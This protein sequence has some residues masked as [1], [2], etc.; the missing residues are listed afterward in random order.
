MW[1]LV[2]AALGA[3]CPVPGAL[4]HFE[5]TAEQPYQVGDVGIDVTVRA[6]D[7]NGNQVPLCDAATV[8]GLARREAGETVA[9]DTTGPFAAGEVVLKDVFVTG[10]S[11]RVALERG[12]AGPVAG[13]YRPRRLPG[14]L[15]ILPPLFAI[16]LAIWLRRALVALVAGVWLGALFVHDFSPMTALLKTFDTYLPSTLTDSGHAA[17]VLFTMALGG[18]VGVI[19]KSGGTKALVDIMARRAKSRRSAQLVAWLSGMVVF[20]DDYANCLLVGNTVRP[21]ADER[22]ISREKLSFLVD[23]TAAPV[24]TVALVSTWIGYQLGL[25][26]GAGV[27]LEG[28]AYDAFLSM[29][30]YSFYALFALGFVGLIAWSGRDFGPMLKAE[31]RAIATGD[32]FRPGSQPLLDKEL[33]ELQPPEGKKL[34]WQNA[35]LPIGVVVGTVIIGLYFNGR[36][37]VEASEGAAAADAASV[38]D[39]IGS[40]DSYAVLLWASFLGGLVAIGSVLATRTLDISE[41]MDAWVGGAKAMV[42]AVLILV[43]AWAIG[44]MC[45]DHLHTGDW[46]L[47]Q[48]RPSGAWLPL[49]TFLVSAVIALAT[50]SSF[51]TMAIVIPLAAPMVWAVT[52]GDVAATADWGVRYA[53]L[54]AVL[55]GA[56]FGDHCSPI[57]DTTIMSSMA[58]GSDHLDHVRTQ[59]PYAILIA[60][61]SMVVGY[62]P[63]GFGLSPWLSLPLGF[64]IL[65]AT[66]LLLGKKAEE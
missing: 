30:P 19:G 5:V 44:D 38:R 54:A 40:A 53:T 45:K 50:G 8:A 3:A 16:G 18:M 42:M 61:V 13:T 22:S 48:V 47:S 14:V 26:G 15:S 12:P 2:V 58:S 17:I 23:S 41:A 24:A 52:G 46:V 60:A 39:I 37:A 33:T 62:I 29:L 66:V 57:S 43:L 28:N 35:V 21:L 6:V 10:D 64:A 32:L 56:V 31:K 9:I 11:A 25:I 51:S 7:A 34:L 59:T 63:A 20:F 49:I 65:T 55:S 36:A 4:D 1:M 27:P